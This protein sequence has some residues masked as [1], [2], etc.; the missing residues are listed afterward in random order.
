VKCRIRPK[1]SIAG[2]HTLN[3]LHIKYELSRSNSSWDIAL[4]WFWGCNLMAAILD[5]WS[6]RNL[7][8][9][10]TSP[11]GTSPLDMKLLGEIMTKRATFLAFFHDWPLWP[12]KVSEMKRK[13]YHDIKSMRCTYDK[14]LRTIGQLLHEQLQFFRYFVLAPYWPGW[15]S[16]HVETRCQHN[17]DLY[18]YVYQVLYFYL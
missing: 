10:N 7:A 17:S 6:S 3:Y 18:E 1:F 15:E 14:K 2:A 9:V 5:V 16:D 11:K 13:E 8:F 12:W 4:W